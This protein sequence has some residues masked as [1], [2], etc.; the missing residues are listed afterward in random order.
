MNLTLHTNLLFHHATFKSRLSF[1]D[2]CPLCPQLHPAIT[3]PYPTEEE[4]TTLVKY[5]PIRT[6]LLPLE[7]LLH[8]YLLFFFLLKDALKEEVGWLNRNKGLID[9]RW[10]GQ[11]RRGFRRGWSFQ[12]LRRCGLPSYHSK[13]NKTAAFTRKKPRTIPHTGLLS[14]HDKCIEISRGWIILM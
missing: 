4:T 3:E 8:L 14:Q 9:W 11:R 13:Q 10:S 2:F 6:T 5:Y 12:K 1:G 7:E